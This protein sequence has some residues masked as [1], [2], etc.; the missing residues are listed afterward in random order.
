VPEVYGTANL[1]GI[2][3]ITVSAM[4][5]AT[6]LGPGITGLAIDLGVPLPEQM[7]WM[8]AWCLVGCF[9]LA[10]AASRVTKREAA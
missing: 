6:A 7:I 5:F 3:A 9:A 8:G 2:R 4:V 10:F 1:G